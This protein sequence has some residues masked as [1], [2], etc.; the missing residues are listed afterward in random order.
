M[1]KK[2][3]VREYKETPRPMG[4]YQVKNKANGKVLIGSSVNVSAILNRLKFEL[5]MGNC[6][7]VVLQEEWKQ[8]GPEMFEF[9]VLELLK[10]ADDP[11]CDRAEDLH[12]LEALWI[13][14]LAPF[15]EKG[16]NRVAKYGT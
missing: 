4:I 10:P 8:F 6:R 5:Q 3:K 1:D 9:D 12:T 13:E 11:T 14:R 7:E 16:Y 15:G 2:A